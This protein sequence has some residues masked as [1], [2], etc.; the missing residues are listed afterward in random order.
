[1][2]IFSCEYVNR[3]LIATMFF[4]ACSTYTFHDVEVCCRDRTHLVNWNVISNSGLGIGNF[5]GKVYP[6]LEVIVVVPVRTFR[7]Y[8]VSLSLVSMSY[9]P[10]V[11]VLVYVPKVPFGTSGE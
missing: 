5:E 2:F 1:M 9:I 4:C 6:P 10:M 8:G 7:H 3:P 11:K